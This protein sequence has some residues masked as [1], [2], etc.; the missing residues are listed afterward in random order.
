MPALLFMGRRWSVG[1]DEF[2]LPSLCSMALRVVWSIALVVILV[3][4]VA[5]S[6]KVD[7]ADCQSIAIWRRKQR[8][9]VTCKTPDQTCMLQVVSLVCRKPYA[10]FLS[11]GVLQ[12]H[13]P[14]PYYPWYQLSVHPPSFVDPRSK[15]DTVKDGAFWDL[16][17]L[18]VVHALWFY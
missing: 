9:S 2:A 15:P 13:N 3:S 10:L 1:G 5:R 18:P 16:G 6:R 14:M 8:G 11:L 17:P 4:S 7:R 12:Q